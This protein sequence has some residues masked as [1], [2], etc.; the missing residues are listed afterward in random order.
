MLKIIILPLVVFCIT[1]FAS[2]GEEI[3]MRL[4]I[5]AGAK[6]SKQ[7]TRI[8]NSEQKL[9]RYKI[10]NISKEEKKLLLEYLIE[11]AS[12]SNYPLVPGF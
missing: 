11:H 12:D 4:N 2:S 3:A 1:V 10:V 8:F 5:P 7:W 9:K 6:V